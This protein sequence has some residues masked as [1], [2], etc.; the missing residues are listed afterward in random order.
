MF[1]S[2]QSPLSCKVVLDL[3]LSEMTKDVKIVLFLLLGHNKRIN[4][5]FWDK[6]K[7]NFTYSEK[8]MMLLGPHKYF[9]E[10]DRKY[11]H[12][13]IQFCNWNHCICYFQNIVLSDIVWFFFCFSSDEYVLFLIQCFDQHVLRPFQHCQTLY[14]YVCYNSNKNGIL[15]LKLNNRKNM[16]ELYIFRKEI[17]RKKDDKKEDKNKTKK[18]IKYKNKTKS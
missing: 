5:G 16:Q 10:I 14:K 15:T 7:T 1:V 11:F 8:V 3:Y 17:N 18:T 9:Q 12:Y 6:E 2:K 4:G 13:F